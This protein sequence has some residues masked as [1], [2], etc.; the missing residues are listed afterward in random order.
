MADYT[1]IAEVGESIVGVLWEEIQSDALVK[2]LIDNELRI[3]LESPFDLR[4]NDSVRLS[5][6][7]YRITEDPTT[8]N[9][10][11]VQGNGTRLRKPP[12]TLDLLYLVTPLVGSP[13]EQQIILG[14]VMQVLYDRAI[15]QGPDLVGSLATSAE[16]I[17]VIL[18]PVALEETTRVWQAMEMTYRLSIVYLVRVAML[19]SRYE[20]PTQ[21]V[22]S[23]RDD[24]GQF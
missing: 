17:R 15:L 5:I 18:N 1:V 22:V 14:K 11:P 20:E 12:L 19:D 23:K 3:S 6:Y 24:Y 7:L 21:P 8:K 4:D 10:F 16:E 2:G 13:R 9:R